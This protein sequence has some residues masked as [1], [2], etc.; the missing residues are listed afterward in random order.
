[1][2]LYCVNAYHNVPADLHFAGPGVI[3]LDDP[4]AAFLFRD[5]PENFLT[6]AQAERA[7]LLEKGRAA[8]EAP[9]EETKALDEPQRD[10]AVRF[11]ARKK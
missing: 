5:A 4:K 6:L 9:G 3:E 1:M 2:K 7:G 8:D 10:R 11:P